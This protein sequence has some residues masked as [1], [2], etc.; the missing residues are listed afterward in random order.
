MQYT[1]ISYITK[2][3]NTLSEKIEVFL[4]IPSLEIE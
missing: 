1:R 3:I 2:T 4:A